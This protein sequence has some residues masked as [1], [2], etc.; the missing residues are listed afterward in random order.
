MP[1]MS[2]IFQG[3]SQEYDELINHEDYQENIRKT[4]RNLFDFSD[5]SIIEFGVGTG[6]LTKLYIEDARQAFCYDR[7]I[8]MLER[9]K[10]NLAG[11]QNKIRFDI[12]DNLKIGTFR[13]QP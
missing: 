13:R 9:A 2:E 7:S 8:H 5:K 6:R 10:I 1:S 4:L 12:L 3:Y 11:F